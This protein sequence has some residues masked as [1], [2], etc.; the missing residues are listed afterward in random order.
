M[1]QIPIENKIISKI[2]KKNMAQN[3]SSNEIALVFLAIYNHKLTI[4]QE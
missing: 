1:P 2:I 3:L 4:L